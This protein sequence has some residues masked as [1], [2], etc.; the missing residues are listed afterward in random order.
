MARSDLEMRAL[1]AQSLVCLMVALGVL[2]WS[3]MFQEEPGWWQM[4]A[5]GLGSLAII[6]PS[7][8]FVWRSQ[9]MLAADRVV[10]GVRTNASADAE[11]QQRAAQQVLGLAAVKLVAT[12]ILMVIAYVLAG[13]QAQWVLVGIA[14]AA[15][16]A[17]LAAWIVSASSRPARGGHS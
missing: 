3:A 12:M 5:S 16:G 13:P 9:R 4:T 8:F 17:V 6:G 2:V 11:Q 15:V 1:G 14:A 7:A 10:D